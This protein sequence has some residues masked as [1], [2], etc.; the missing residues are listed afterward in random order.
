M[1]TLENELENALAAAQREL[2]VDQI[3]MHPEL[4]LRDLLALAN[5]KFDVLLD[6][7][8]IGELLGSAAPGRATPIGR[9]PAARPA[10]GR[11]RPAPAPA[12]STVVPPPSSSDDTDTG[13]GDV[14]TRTQ[15]TRDR[16]DDAVLEALRNLGP[17]A[18]AV[19]LRG[20][21][22]GT[23]FQIR[24]SLARLI[25]SGAATWEGQARGTK[26]SAVD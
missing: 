8:T 20:A 10:N 9:P 25:E 17:Q 21:C 7:V 1:S 2:F 14:N 12:S 18:R 24:A 19:D 3:R 5:G 22:G 6:D 15:I 13:S 23:P 11:R 26:Y 16:Y 4:T